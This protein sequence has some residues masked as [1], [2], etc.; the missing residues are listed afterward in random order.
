M[1]SYGFGKLSSRSNWYTKYFW[2]QLDG[3]LIYAFVEKENLNIIVCDA[4]I[5]NVPSAVKISFGSS[6]FSSIWNCFS[7]CGIS[8][9]NLTS[10]GKVHFPG[11]LD[12]WLEMSNCYTTAAN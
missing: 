3:N 10:S 12:V 9:L 2:K 8:L 6:N 1:E 7:V 11:A 4:K 5:L